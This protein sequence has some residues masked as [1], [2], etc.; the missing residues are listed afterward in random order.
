MC[1]TLHGRG[2]FSCIG[3]DLSKCEITFSFSFG[4]EQM[5][6]VVDSHD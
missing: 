4:L 2:A 1:V 5:L 3:K 6:T